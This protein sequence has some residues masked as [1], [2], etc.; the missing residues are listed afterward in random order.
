[1]YDPTWSFALTDQTVVGYM[2][3]CNFI[4][5]HYDN[6]KYVIDDLVDPTSSALLKTKQLFKNQELKNSYYL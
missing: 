6:V 4:L 1:M 3:K 2:A 5:P